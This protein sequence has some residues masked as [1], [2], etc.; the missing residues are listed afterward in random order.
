MPVDFV[1]KLTTFELFPRLER[2]SLGGAVAF[3]GAD[4]VKLVKARMAAGYPLK[5]L[6]LEAVKASARPG[7]EDDALV[8]LAS[9]LPIFEIA[10]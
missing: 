7:L 3:G 5:A 10:A 2:L 6:R 1:A 4:L 8:E 9:L